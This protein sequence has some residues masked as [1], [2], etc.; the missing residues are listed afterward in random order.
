MQLNAKKQFSQF[1]FKRIKSI[2]ICKTTKTLNMYQKL[3]L[4]GELS[5]IILFAIS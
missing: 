2:C 5:L 3:Y 4:S 1:I